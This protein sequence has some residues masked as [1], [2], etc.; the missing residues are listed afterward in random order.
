MFNR[1]TDL[2]KVVLTEVRKQF[3]CVYVCIL[4]G[5]DQCYYLPACPLCCAVCCHKK[6]KKKKRTD[7]VSEQMHTDLN[8]PDLS[9]SGRLFP[10]T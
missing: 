9:P 5:H 2:C 4:F 3:V 7:R 10:L 6:R 1:S 8:T